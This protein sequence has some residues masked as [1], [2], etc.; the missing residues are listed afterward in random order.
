MPSIK[1]SVDQD[2]SRAPKRATTTPQ[3]RKMTPT[4]SEFEEAKNWKFN[5]KAMSSGGMAAYIYDS[6]DKRVRLQLPQMRVPFG[7]RE[8][9]TDQN[10]VY[11]PSTGRPN[12]DLDASDPD[13]VK[14]GHKVDDALRKFIVKN[15]PELFKKQHDD[16]F[17]KAVFRGVTVPPTNSDYNPL[18]RTKINKDG[19]Y[20]TTVKIVEDPG[21]EDTPLRWKKG[22]I[23][24]IESGDHVLPIVD[25]GSLWCVGNSCGVAF[26]LVSVLLYK[27]SSDNDDEFNLPGVAGMQK[28]E[29]TAT[30]TPDE[31]CV[32]VA[33]EGAVDCAMDP[34]Q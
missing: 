33:M 29:V 1:R 18:L 24:D 17:I 30:E 13:L 22:S 14:W 15:S 27:K 26:N 5:I 31:P 23:S 20:A 9:Y 19:T 6:S 28:A 11:Q 7:V 4:Y 3:G 8:G 16:G 34:F 25:V 10:G 12:L 32:D 21:S 2:S